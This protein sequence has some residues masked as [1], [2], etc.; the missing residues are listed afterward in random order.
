MLGVRGRHDDVDVLRGVGVVALRDAGHRVRPHSV[1]PF[2][3]VAADA[4]GHEG[5]ARR[6]VGSLERGIQPDLVIF[7]VLLIY[8]I[9]FIISLEVLHMCVFVKSAFK[10]ALNQIE[11]H[12]HKPKGSSLKKYYLKNF[13]KT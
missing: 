7:S 12:Y 1:H 9:S 11:S 4:A 2:A 13:L 8:R 10:T 5:A 3:R 6:V